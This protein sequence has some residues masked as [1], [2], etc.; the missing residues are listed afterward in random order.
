MLI[1]RF[2]KAW[3]TLGF[4]NRFC[5]SHG[6]SR[7]VV[8][9][10]FIWLTVTT[11]VQDASVAQQL[12][13]WH[14]SHTA[15]LY[16]RSKTSWGSTRLTKPGFHKFRVMLFCGKR[17]AS[18]RQRMHGSSGQGLLASTD[19][20]CRGSQQPRRASPGSPSSTLGWKGLSG[21]TG[22][23]PKCITS[24]FKEPATLSYFWDL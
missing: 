2:R 7:N 1:L 9:E 12:T 8:L 11:T 19:T 18:H 3:R 16:P 22:T 10:H 4:R 24:M 14:Q 15:P 20:P 21:T 13:T 5:I 6:S 17:S 23:T